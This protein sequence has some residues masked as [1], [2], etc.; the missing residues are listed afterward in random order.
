MLR[1]LKNKNQN[2]LGCYLPL[3]GLSC[4]SHRHSVLIFPRSRVPLHRGLTSMDLGER[5]GM[6]SA[7]T[8]TLFCT[9]DML[10]LPLLCALG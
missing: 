2:R 4:L 1:G 3:L 9:P 7:G 5:Q 10:M 6:R 8:P